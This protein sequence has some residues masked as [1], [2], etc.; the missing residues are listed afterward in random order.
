M[1][2]STPPGAMSAPLRTTLLSIFISL[3][4]T[5]GYAQDATP[6]DKIDPAFR[7]VMEQPVTNGRRETKT[8]LPTVKITPNKVTVAAGSPAEERY[9]CI[10]YTNDVAAVRNNGVVVNS[11]L[12]KFVTAW[13]TLAQIEQL[14]K[15]GTVNYVAAPVMDQ[16]HND[17]AVA[18]TGAALLH[19]ARLNNTVYKGKGVLV[20]IFDSGIDWTHPDFRDPLDQTKSRI[21]RIWDQTINPIAG[22]VSPTGFNYGVEYTQAQIS[23]EIDGSPTGY[24]RERDTNGHG[25]HVAGTAA[26]NGMAIPDTRKHTGMAPEADIIVIKGGDGSFS[27]TNIINGLT[28]LKA[29]ATTLGKPIVVNMS[30]G[31][32]SGPHDGTRAYELAVDDFTSSAAGRAVVIS[33]GNDNGSNIHNQI[34]LAS[35]NTTNITF[36]VPSATTGT[37]VFDYRIYTNGNPNISATAIAPGG[38]SI[39][40]TP[41]QS[42]SGAVLSNGFNI[43]LR[44]QIDPDN[45]HRYVDVFVQ[46]ASGSVDPAGIW[47]LSITNNAPTTLTMHGWLYYRLAPF[48][49]T[50]LVNGNSDYLVGSPGNANSAITVAAY[51]ARPVWYSYATNSGWAANGSKMDSIATFSS[52][53]PRRDGVLKPE[54]TA[55]GQHVISAL[56]SASTPDASDIIYPGKYRKN[57]GTSMSAPVVTGGI[58]LLLQSNPT[59]NITQIRTTLFSNTAKD[60]MT[61]LPG[62]TPNNTYGYGKLDIFKAVSS[63][64]ACAPVNRVTYQYDA[65]AFPNQEASVG[66]LTTQRF[67]VRFTPNTN[68]KAAGAYFHSGTSKAQMVL[69]VRANTS[70]SP[71]ALLGTL[72]IPD[73]SIASSTWNYADLSSLNIPINNGSDYFIVLYASSGTPWSLRREAVVP[74]MRTLISFNNGTSWSAAAEDYKIRSV[75]Y[76]NDQL[77]A[78]IAM[79]DTEDKRRILGNNLFV[80]N[81]CQLIATVSPEGA[82]P[83]T[84]S[85]TANVWIETGVPQVG[86]K[87]F[88]ARHYQ[89][90]PKTDP[91]TATGR[92]TL[93]F[94]QAE[95]DAFNADP[96]STLDLPTGPTDAPGKANLFI[97]K[98]AGSSSDGSGLPASYSGTPTVINPNDNDIVWNATANRWEV[99]FSVSGFSG[100]IVQTEFSA[101][102]LYV[103]S[104]TGY[105][106]ETANLLKWKISCMD[107]EPLFD[108]QRSSNGVNY[109]SIGSDIATNGCNKIFNFKDKQP[110]PGN[111][112]YRIKITDNGHDHYTRSILLQ[113]D[114]GLVTTLNPNVI[115]KGESILVSL[116]E[117]E[118]ILRV[119]DAT[120]RQVYSTILT[121]GVQSIALPVTQSGPYFYNIQNRQGKLITGKLIVK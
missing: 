87:P 41:G 14:S 73:T 79:A 54:I 97:T 110:L 64:F 67:A 91:T 47:T 62:G 90:T 116:V 35:A 8:Y 12:P 24:V 20:A 7:F 100:F 34:T 33:A 82:N 39:T 6:Q 94:T 28:Y 74:D 72:N 29:L 119:M 46:R 58:A 109:T 102:P 44:N 55:M 25:T 99:S 4:Y 113:M 70:G 37:D 112:Y 48:T 105:Q 51:N 31:G 115:K 38:E 15:L 93:Y 86:G 80:D 63:T 61:E 95:F 121:K 103:E 57:Q 11:V 69:E 96:N 118:G 42:L 16:L 75:V 9:D 43:I 101:L 36:N 56:S 30:L 71:G 60:P 22:E 120:G 40:A 98:Y 1:R 23:D 107:T 5:T 78:G 85:T 27:N 114:K 77:A 76:T 106:Q 66:G 88:V 108:I 49:G 26:G 117:T 59:A 13:A 32:Q 84:D 10:V 3:V 45:N 65:S 21:L 50:T 83:I 68:G 81:S 2:N 17:I 18:S 53:G 111:N 19:Q 52:R 92:I 89:L 104:F